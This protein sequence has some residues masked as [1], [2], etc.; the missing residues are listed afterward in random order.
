MRLHSIKTCQT[1]RFLINSRERVTGLQFF[2]ALNPYEADDEETFAMDPIGPMTGDCRTLELP[3][4][5]DRI[6]VT[7]DESRAGLSIMY[8]IEG[9]VL[10]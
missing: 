2:M 3:E 1:D 5:L 7:L 9:D 10:D 4:G 6:T 8:R